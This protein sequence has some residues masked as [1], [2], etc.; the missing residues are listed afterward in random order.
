MVS[1]GVQH[2]KINSQNALHIPLRVSEKNIPYNASMQ[3]N[4]SRSKNKNMS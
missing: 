4:C 2:K 3:Q 1:T